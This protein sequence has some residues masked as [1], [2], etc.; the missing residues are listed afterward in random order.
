MPFP[1]VSIR[2]AIIPGS[3]TLKPRTPTVEELLGNLPAIPGGGR[4]GAKSW[5][6]AR[7][8]LLEGAE[9]PLPIGCFREVQKSIKYSVHQLLSNQ[10]EELEID[11]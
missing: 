8:L 2:D 3:T 11:S 10:V 4:G 6:F 5:S 9:S 7:A 1:P